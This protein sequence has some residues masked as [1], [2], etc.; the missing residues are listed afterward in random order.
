MTDLTG[1]TTPDTSFDPAKTQAQ[2]SSRPTVSHMLGEM[3]W[4]LTQSPVH[5]HFTLAD[6]EWMIMPPLLL[7]QYRVFHG[8]QTPVGF[9]LWAYLSVEAEAKLEAGAQKLRPDEW[10]GGDRL[11]LVELV[12]PFATQENKLVEHMLNDLLKGPMKG[13]SFK[14]H[15]TDPKSGHRQSL[16]ING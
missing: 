10:K 4:I 11:W 16:T 9:A 13:K 3:V 8:E 15:Q 7:E 6:L 1:T 5:K 2:A 12:A 14:L